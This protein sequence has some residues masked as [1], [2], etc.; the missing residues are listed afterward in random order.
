MVDGFDDF[1]R[2][3]GEALWRPPVNSFR[4]IQRSKEA[5]LAVERLPSSSLS[6]QVFV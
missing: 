4:Y 5:G 3:K 6:A 2:R 1:G